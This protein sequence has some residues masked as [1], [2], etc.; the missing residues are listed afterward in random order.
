MINKFSIVKLTKSK[1][2]AEH[3][4]VDDPTP[5]LLIIRAYSDSRQ[6]LVRYPDS[7]IHRVNHDDILTKGTFELDHPS[8]VSI[9]KDMRAVEIEYRKNEAYHTVID[10]RL[11][12]LGLELTQRIEAKHRAYQERQQAPA[13]TVPVPDLPVAEATNSI[14]PTIKLLTSIDN[15]LS[16]LIQL[17]GG[18]GNDK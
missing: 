10:N 15:K 17:W 5:R 6:Y 13:F 4:T 14:D 16:T 9:A 3:V 7:H 8:Y 12:Q 18:Q 1:Y 2:A 11:P